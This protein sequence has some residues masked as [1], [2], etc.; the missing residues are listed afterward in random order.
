ML[1][2]MGTMLCFVQSRR[3]RILQHLFV[4]LVQLINMKVVGVFE[5]DGCGGIG[6]PHA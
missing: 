6:D 5:G 1:I 4:Y 2:D 3:T